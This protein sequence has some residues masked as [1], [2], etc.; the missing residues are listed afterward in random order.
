M[1]R[2]RIALLGFSGVLGI[3]IQLMLADWSIW[4]LAS[5]VCLCAGTYGTYRC[6]AAQQ[7]IVARVHRNGTGRR[8]SPWEPLWW[9]L[10]AGSLLIGIWV[11]T[12]WRT[13]ALLT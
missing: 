12:A 4:L 1:R 8:G 5:G 9:A 7:A 2:L 11:I 13:G 10:P 3:V 6:E